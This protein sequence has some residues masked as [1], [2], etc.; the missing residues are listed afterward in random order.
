MLNKISKRPVLF[1]GLVFLLL[2]LLFNVLEVL[3]IKSAHI[4]D[5]IHV[6]PTIFIYEPI[7][8]IFNLGKLNQI[9]FIPLA[10]IIDFLIGLIIS[11]IFTKFKYIKNNLLISLIIAFLIYWFI[12]TFQWIPI[13]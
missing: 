12:I 1:G 4:N 13:I 10:V 3:F 11:F 7:I 6:F 9:Y 5:I 8:N 2:S